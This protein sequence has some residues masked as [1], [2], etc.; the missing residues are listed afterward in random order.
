[1]RLR[2]PGIVALLATLVAVLSCGGADRIAL[3]TSA[4]P[5]TITRPSDS[6]LLAGLYASGPVALD[7]VA[8]GGI[9]PSGSTAPTVEVSWVSLV[10]GTV[11][12]GTSAT[13]V[14]LRSLR[15]IPVT[16]V[17]GGFD[18]L[19][20][21]AH[22]GDT[23]QVSVSRAG[24]P[25]A[26]AVLPLAA[27]PAPRIVRSRPP[28]G[29]TQAPLNTIITLVFSEPLDPSSVNP[30]SVTL[31]TAGSSVAG[32]ARILADPGYVVEFTPNT[33]LAPLRTYS[34]TVSGVV[35]LWGTP[36]AAPT[37]IDFTTADSVVSITLSPD[38]VAMDVGGELYFNASL[39]FTSGEVSTQPYN[40][41]T[42][43][44]SAPEVASVD[45]RSGRITGI[46]PGTA[47]I[48]ARDI[49]G[50]AATARIT[51]NLAPSSIGAIIAS[52][53][54]DYGNCG[55]YAVEPDGSNGRF[56][57]FNDTDIDPAWSP[58]GRW[59]AFRSPRA[60]DRAT[61][62]NCYLDLY[63]MRAD[64]SGIVRSLTAG[65]GLAVGGMSWAPDGSRIVFSASP[66]ST[67]GITSLE[68]LYVVGVDG[69]A[70]RK[71]VS[72]PAGSSAAWPDWSPDGSRIVYNVVFPGD[73][74]TVDVVN[75]D[76]TND[77]RISTPS[78]SHGDLR[79]HW[80]PDGRHIAFMRRYS[81]RYAYSYFSSQAFVMN[82]DG[83][84]VTL[85]TPGSRWAGFPVWSP[86]GSKLA[87][88]SAALGGLGIVN[89]DGSEGRAIP[90]C[91]A[92]DFST[93]FSW[94]R[95]AAAVPPLARSRRVP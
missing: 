42:W 92:N 14:N 54:D 77:V 44:S 66:F 81:D 69:S 78:A 16:I 17:D 91:C 43:I 50:V 39:T 70:L 89:A 38:S 12:D 26:S 41:V 94:R 40:S 79:P 29:R 83:S 76:G 95:T 62:R 23:I 58:D 67:E 18:P 35:S 51:V 90:M 53:C 80:S 9:A 34:L 49:G 87:L 47:L 19:A 82:A 72:A 5:G 6:T 74:S 46:A 59:I 2:S 55:M 56:I 86:D 61:A 15:S 93:V 64:S 84:N 21:P 85:I 33:L 10:P 31:T 88:T 37:S 30:S 13:V 3:P 75:A 68:A 52:L 27:R 25:D 36:L 8:A 20:V 28:R 11:P 65:R 57:T 48:T 63:I 1:M 4:G 24:Q 22:L 45:F 7:R 32:A 71:I 60:C 73:T